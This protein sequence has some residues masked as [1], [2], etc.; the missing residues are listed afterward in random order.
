MANIEKLHN[1]FLECG[2]VCTDTRQV[3]AGSMFFA[4]K[5]ANFNGNMFALQALE[6]GA[7]YA[8][9][10]EDIGENNPRL[11]RVDNVLKALQ[12]LSRYHRRQFPI[13][14][15]AVT[16]SNGKT[17]TKELLNAVLNTRYQT[18]ATIGNLNNH[19][20]VPLTLLRLNK[21]HQ[22]AVIEMGA[23]HCHEIE[24]LCHIA[25]PGFGIVTNIG[26]AHLEGFGGI[27][28]VIRAKSEMYSF[29]KNDVGTSFVNADDNLLMERSSEN[30]RILYGTSGHLQLMGKIEG[31]FPFISFS[32]A[33]QYE[34]NHFVSGIVN[35]NLSG[36]FHLSN[37]LCATAVGCYFGLTADQIKEGIESYKP[38]NQRSQWIESGST[39]ILVDTYNANPGSVSAAV[40]LIESLPAKGDKLLIIGDMFELGADSI[41][42]HYHILKQI[43]QVPGIHAFVLGDEF[44]KAFEQEPSLFK[45][46]LPFKDRA[47]LFSSIK[48]TDRKNLTVLL[49]GS[50]GMKMEEF[51]SAFD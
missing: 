3:Q 8:V 4:L 31:A 6:K 38:N 45:N 18:L 2:S 34:N 29:L 15:I 21:Q 40:K 23:N 25:E 20:G 19:I 35:S 13:P 16:G 30:K 27:Q 17:T 24:A 32:Y 26:K 1:K 11:I 44:C 46:I 42:E 37:L 39:R 5:G 43:S 51:I 28:G 14:V 7:G 48:K 22:I 50:R 10:D 9:V 33:W 47:S 36:E 12:N 41:S 49:K